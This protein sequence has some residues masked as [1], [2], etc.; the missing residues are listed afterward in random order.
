MI[1]R[2]IIRLAST[3]S[4]KNHWLIW[5]DSEGRIIEF[6]ELDNAEQ[7]TQLTEK[8][9]Q[10][11][12]ICLLPG[13]D[14]PIREVAIKGAMN[15]HMLKALP[16]LMEDELASD[17]D[18]LHFSIIA[19]ETNLLH[20][21]ICEKQKINMWLGWLENA[22]ISCR[23]FIPEGLTL[24]LGADGVWQ[25]VLLDNQWIIRENQY[26]AWSCEQNMLDIMLL[27][28][29]ED[30]SDLKIAS[31]TPPREKKV[32]EWSYLPPMPPM[33]L[34]ARGVKGNKFNILT[35]EFKPKKESNQQLERWRLPIILAICLFVILM[36]NTYLKNSQVQN[37]IL[38]VK[39]D[40]EAVYQQAF[41]QQ[42]RLKYPRIKKKIRSM[43]VGVEGDVDSS[44]LSM[45]NELV[46]ALESSPKLEVNNIKFDSKKKEIR[47][48]ASADN[49]QSFEK[50]NEVLGEH[51]NV[52]QGALN[53]NKGSVSG[54]LTIRIK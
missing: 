26:I 52:D 43:L 28:K 17:V 1:E 10:R 7:L 18:M 3:A 46:P 8:A 37:E 49:F 44:F 23:K 12:V 11:L 30:D 9:V 54:L 5:S 22:D 40:V 20:V 31:H 41:P 35:G 4:Q 16:Y 14:V 25:A 19:K 13:G 36:L 50:F 51:F 24:P 53:S 34:L 45:L 2:L 27:S 38:Q 48:S 47:L 29:N 6:G 15:R 32:G 42:S 33:E 21:C 39:Q